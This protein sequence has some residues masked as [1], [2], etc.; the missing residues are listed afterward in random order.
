MNAGKSVDLLKVAHNYKE[1]GKNVLL[2]TSAIDNRYGIGKI[3]S[4]MG[5]QED[6]IAIETNDNIYET[7]KNLNMVEKIHCVLIDEGQFLS[8]LQVKQLTD[9]VDLFD[10]PVICY[11]LRTDFRG[12]PF[13]GSQY[14][15]LWADSIEEIKTVCHCGRK[16]TCNA[17][18]VDGKIVYQ[19]EQVQ[20]G[21]NESYKALCRKDWKAG[22]IQ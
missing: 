16:A 12:E 8:K 10:V 11:G 4:R 1:Q 3:T 18:I 17:R 21:G 5:V 7:F 20:I 9:V 2:L 6:A 19:G 13:E 22:K 15:L 14:L